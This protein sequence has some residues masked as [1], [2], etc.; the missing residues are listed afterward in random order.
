MPL[1]QL[2]EITKFSPQKS[3]IGFVEKINVAKKNVNPHQC[4]NK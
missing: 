4:A 3:V 1:E 2:Q